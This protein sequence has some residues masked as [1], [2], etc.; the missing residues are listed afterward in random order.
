MSISYCAPPLQAH[1]GLYLSLNHGRDFPQQT[2]RGRGFPDPKIGPLLYVRTQY[3]QEVTLRFANRRDA[4]RFF[5]DTAMATNTMQIVE[6]T[7]VLGEKCYGDWDVCYIAQE[8]C[9]HQSG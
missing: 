7:L 4:K 8:F 5:P 9:R 3:G 2:M 1:P 6:G